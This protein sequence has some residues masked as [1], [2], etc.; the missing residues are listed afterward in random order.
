MKLQI[1]GRLSKKEK[2]KH[3]NLKEFIQASPYFTQE[4]LLRHSRL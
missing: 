4:S 3:D 2:Y 1:I